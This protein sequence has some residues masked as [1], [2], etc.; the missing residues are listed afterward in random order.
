M[1]GLAAGVARGGQMAAYYTKPKRR[2][3]S[4][5][6]MLMILGGTVALGVA[7]VFFMGE[8]S[9][10]VCACDALAGCARRGGA[11]VVCL[12]QVRASLLCRPTGGGIGWEGSGELCNLV[13]LLHNPVLLLCNLVLLLHNPVLLLCNLVLRLVAPPL[14]ANCYCP[15]LPTAC[16]S[17][18]M[19]LLGG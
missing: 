13:L 16:H 8:G 4:G 12:G 11:A 7:G 10:C 2:G 9:A 15:L 3:L 19:D 18:V 14:H 17:P 6:A 1:L 5:E